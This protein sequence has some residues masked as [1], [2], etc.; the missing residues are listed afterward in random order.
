M[1]SINPRFSWWP[2][3]LHE[4]TSELDV[5]LLLLGRERTGTGLHIDRTEAL[6]LLIA[7]FGG[8][9]DKAFAMWLLVEASAAGEVRRIHEYKLG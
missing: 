2:C 7:L 8:D 4:T 3:S 9:M 1:R 5:C 6:N